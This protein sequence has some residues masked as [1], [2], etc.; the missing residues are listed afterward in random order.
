MSYHGSSS[1]G[2]TAYDYNGLVDPDAP[3]GRV[4]VTAEC[5]FDPQSMATQSTDCKSYG[6][7][8]IQSDGN[9][10]YFP[11]Q[12]AHAIFIDY[13]RDQANPDKQYVGDVEL[14]CMPREV[15]DDVDCLTAV[16]EIIECGTGDWLYD[17]EV[18]FT[19]DS[20]FPISTIVFTTDPLDPSV[21]VGANVGDNNTVNLANPLLPGD[22]VSVELGINAPNA[23]AGDELCFDLT[24]HDEDEAFC[25]SEQEIELCVTL[26]DCRECN[27]SIVGIKFY[28]VNGN[29][30]WDPN[31][32]PLPN[33]TINLLYPNGTTPSV[34]TDNSGAFVFDHIPAGTGYHLFE[35][36]QL[37]WMQ[38]LPGNAPNGYNV[39]FVDP[40][41]ATEV[42]YFGNDKAR[43]VIDP[44][45]EVEPLVVGPQAKGVPVV[46]FTVPGQATAM[47]LRAAVIAIDDQDPQHR[48][49]SVQVVADLD[50]DGEFDSLDPVLGRA[51]VS[52]DSG[53]VKVDFD[54]P[55]ELATTD[56]AQLLIVADF[57]EQSQDDQAQASAGVIGR[58]GA[59][60]FGLALGLVILGASAPVSRRRRSLTWVTAGATVVVGLALNVACTPEPEPEALEAYRI[61]VVK[62]V[63]TDAVTG[64]YGNVTGIEGATSPWIVIEE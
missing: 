24:V 8:G 34:V 1:A 37:G 54:E 26:P 31:E 51:T 9:A 5:I 12:D 11:M 41:G 46:E 14:T 13:D 64:H 61:S 45:D 38:T 3:E 48:L 28:D 15:V 2:G 21:E 40:H 36:Q 60:G 7:Y 16:N 33:W 19:N 10:G 49:G 55:L 42:L 53:L 57:G 58:W 50:G 18:T 17:W 59:L 32:T 4:W 30:V 47:K 44:N 20:Q 43:I 63:A 56:S 39:D 22:S 27:N 62:V 23:E 52:R 6:A 29:G 35:T 25:C